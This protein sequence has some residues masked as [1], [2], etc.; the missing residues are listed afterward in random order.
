ME[1]EFMIGIQFPINKSLLEQI[2]PLLEKYKSTRSMAV[3][4]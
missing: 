1:K 2:V 4:P 3:V